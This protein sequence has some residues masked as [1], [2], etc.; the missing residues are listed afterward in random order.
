VYALVS[1]SG[2]TLS[3][4]LGRLA[5]EEI[6]GTASDLLA[7]FRPDRPAGGAPAAATPFIGR[8]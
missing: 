6:G 5:A 8:Q 2:M 7:S 1:H 4:L 3:A